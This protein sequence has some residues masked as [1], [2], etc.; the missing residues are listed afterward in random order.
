MASTAL[1]LSEIPIFA[2]LDENERQAL[3][4]LLETEYFKQGQEIFGY[5]DQ[6]DSIYIV[7]SGKVQV[8][9]ENDEGDTLIVSEPGPGEPF[10]EISFLDAGPR[11]ATAHA[12]E[13]TE[14][15]TLTRERLLEFIDQH[16]H[17]AIDLLTVMGRRWRMTDQLLR[18]HVVRNV[19]VVEEE[20]MTFG[21]RVADKVAS[22]GGSWTFIL[23]FG[24]V[25]VVW[26]AV[27]TAL[28]RQKAFDPFPYILLNLVLS[29]LA[30]I[31]APVIM[32][33]Q[34]RQ[35]AK[36]RLQADSDYDVNLKAELEISHLH[37][38][39]DRIYELMHAAVSRQEKRDR[40]WGRMT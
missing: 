27:N 21:Q 31:Q 17:A 19:N 39:V 34:N 5:G 16:A 38:K 3:A 28:L 22:F 25:I 36:D 18:K 23:I 4:H 29:C 33:S 35:A 7:R 11:T 20:R 9:I 37:K 13:D 32:M 10:G 8:F 12:V 24:A 1:I 30:A 14:C 15:L 2:L 40:D 6:G 26:M